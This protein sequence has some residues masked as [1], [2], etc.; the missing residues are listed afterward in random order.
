[1]NRSGRPSWLSWPIR[2][3]SI[4]SK[5]R[6]SDAEKAR[7]ALLR[8][9][10]IYLDSTLDFQIIDDA[11][12][13]VSDPFWREALANRRLYATAIS[14]GP[15]EIVKAASTWTHGPD[16]ALRVVLLQA[17][18]RMGRLDEA[19]DQLTPP[20][21]NRPT[22]AP[23]QPWDEWMLFGDRVAA[24]V[25]SGRFVE[26]DELLT[27]AS[28]EV[29]G[30][31]VAEARAFVA[32]SFAI[33]HLE[34]GRPVSAFRRA[35]ESIT[36]Y[37]QL[38]RSR[39]LPRPYVAATQAL[40]LTG[41][42]AKAASTLAALDALALPI[43]PPTSADL[44]QARAWTA[45]AAGELPT[46]RAILKEAADFAEEIGHLVG[47]TSAL[48]ALAR[49]GHAH[50]VA[51]RL[52]DL[53]ARVDGELVAARAAY[54]DAVA[55]RDSQ[56]LR[57]VSQAFERLGADL[58][59]AEASVESA[60]VSRR[61]GRPRDAAADEHRAAQLLGRCEGATTPMVKMVTAQAR[62]TPGEL[63]AAVQA[64]AGRSNKQIAADTHISVRTVES[65]LQRVYEKLGIS[66][67]RQLT[68]A[69][70]DE[71]GI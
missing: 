63:D 11:L 39:F 44:L 71:P 56:A 23:D 12:A 29:M 18:I 21:D 70:R 37:Q 46:A 64:A 20:L 67:R 6:A 17:L 54:A 52:R 2:A 26:A 8:F 62:L 4:P 59:A 28:R 68:H 40:A 9:D 66:S 55:A 7:V 57:E 31:P 33:L 16:S 32:D 3:P 24:L 65:H 25:Y 35:S 45:A 5:K 34:Q 58:Y 43:W 69:L 30:H 50:Q 10:N 47:A 13:L 61:G 19:I 51:G 15:R 1:M 53:A 27:M 42:A 38:G 49:L 14:S 41:Q 48:H 36:L 22:P 60:A